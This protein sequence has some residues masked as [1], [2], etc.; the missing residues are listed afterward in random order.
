VKNYLYILTHSSGNLTCEYNPVNWDKFNIIFRRSETYHSVLR[1][2]I[3]DVEFPLDG[4]AYIDNIYD[5]YG[6]DTDIECEIQYLVKSTRTYST[7]MEGLIDLSEWTKLRD[8]TSVKIID[9]S[10]MAKFAARDELD[11][12]MTRFYDLAGAALLPTYFDLYNS[13]TVEG[14]TA[15]LNAKY[16]DTSNAIA[17][18][19]TKTGTSSWE[20]FYG[21]S[22][23]D[24]DI[25]EIGTDATLPDESQAGAVAIYTNNKAVS[26]D[27]RYKIGVKVIGQGGGYVGAEVDATTTWSL[28]ID[29]YVGITKVIEIDESGTGDEDI[30]MNET[31]ESAWLTDTILPAGTKNVYQH[32]WG[33]LLGIDDTIDYDFEIQPYLIDLYEVYPAEPDTDVNLLLLHEMGAV[34]LSIITGNL[35][36]LNAPLLGR[37]DSIPRTYD[38][39][40]DYSLIGVA[41]GL[42][43]RGFPILNSNLITSFKDYFTAIDAL[44]NLGMY[45]DQSNTEFVIGAKE[46]FYKVEKIITLGEVQELEISIATEHYF[47]KVK[48]GFKKTVSYEQSSGIQSFNVPVE[49]INE[50]KRIQNTLDLQCPYRGDDQGIEF[51]RQLQ[52]SETA[53]EDSRYDNDLFII[54]GQRDNGDFITMQGLDNFTD[55]DGVYSPEERLNLDITPVRSLLRNSNRLSI[56]S[57]VANYDIQFEHSQYDIALE[58]K[59]SGESTIDETDDIAFADLDEPLYY[60]EQYNFTSEL[61]IAHILQ[62]IS[63]P[64]GYVEFDYLGVTYSGYIIEVSSEP[65][66]RKGNWTLIKRNPNRT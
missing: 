27:I 65:F 3:I 42:L 59:K 28:H 62:L 56:P 45:Y 19:G 50:G 66:N 43:I 14:V 39:D 29:C 44:F 61:T 8:T 33:N 10:T 1:K 38:S 18:S 48:A 47:N 55:I 52:Y 34:L 5:T 54:V 60:P 4:K 22:D 58:T 7:L 46:D 37:T 51:A 24:F 36:P 32:F 31:Y 6:I 64:H 25:N 49:F 15:E 2:Q 13:M 20:E 30:V 53:S 35:D 26:M 41:S 21:I 63:D 57:F 17:L 16:D 11:I 12:N 23:D 40:G 9:N